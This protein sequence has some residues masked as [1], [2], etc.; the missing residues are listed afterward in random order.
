MR[1]RDGVDRPE[2]MATNQ[3]Q[4]D[5]RSPLLAQRAPYGEGRDYGS[6]PKATDV[7]QGYRPY[8]QTNN[9]WV[10]QDATNRGGETGQA[11]IVL[12]ACMWDEEVYGQLLRA[13]LN[14]PVSPDTLKELEL[15]YIQNNINLRVDIQFDEDL[16]FTPVS[17]QRGEEKRVEGSRYWFASRWEF[18]VHLHAARGACSEC[19]LSSNPSRRFPERLPTMFW[20]LKALLLLLVPAHDHAIVQ[21]WFDLGATAEE[22]HSSFLMRQVRQ[23]CLDVRALAR[24]LSTL[25]TAHCAPVRDALA[26]DMRDK[27]SDGASTGDMISLVAGLEKLFSFCEAMKLDVANHQIRTFRYPLIADG[28]SFQRDY[29]QTRISMG[30]LDPDPSIEWF[31]KNTRWWNK[32]QP[33]SE[34]GRVVF[35]LCLLVI[36]PSEPIHEL[37][38]HDSGRISQL[39]EEVSDLIHLEACWELVCN[40]TTRTSITIDQR[41]FCSRLLDLTDG[42]ST[43][44]DGLN[45]VWTC[46]TDALA[47][48]LAREISA[49]SGRSIGATF[50]D[51]RKR[52]FLKEDMDHHVENFRRKL[53]TRVLYH[54]NQF[55][56]FQA[57]RIY[58]LQQ[59]YRQTHQYQGRHI[60]ELE[61]VARRIAHI[62]VIHWRVWFDRYYIPELS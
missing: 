39:R 2:D 6:D 26:F 38:R 55:G 43:P 28:I 60:P 41:T 31:A 51:T 25:L 36:D 22:A 3:A 42:D 17:G 46:H 12:P 50:E 21:A 8:P 40:A 9:E 48:E 4:D 19:A 52:L 24:W 44:E 27:I 45:A 62:A 56:R 49:A 1:G 54:A 15:P 57:L 16:H 34:Y 14:P 32:H 18:N 11:F 33:S 47:T 5:Q 29:F 23:G 53:G 13:S 20:N 30:R 58:E 37:F 35:V 59:N 61:D 10:E 7:R